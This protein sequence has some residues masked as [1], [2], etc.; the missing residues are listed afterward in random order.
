MTVEIKD[1]L[2]RELQHFPK[3][4]SKE[5]NY[6][7]KKGEFNYVPSNMM[8]IESFMISYVAYCFDTEDEYKA[9]ARI[10]NNLLNS[11]SDYEKRRISFRFGLIMAN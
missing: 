10:N 5:S 3:Y 11:E 4:M 2:L 8:R 9:F 6:L 1:K 7:I